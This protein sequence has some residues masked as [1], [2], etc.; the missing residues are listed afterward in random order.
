MSET[1]PA[2]IRAAD[3]VAGMTQLTDF[4]E[5]GEVLRSRKF[6]QASSQLV[7][8]TLMKDVLFLIDGEEHL[9]RKRILTRLLDDD[10]VVGYRDRHLLP[11]IERCLAEEAATRRG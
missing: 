10:A 7:R 11:V 3:A 2:D 8:D 6:I 1:K 5:I 4:E 9:A